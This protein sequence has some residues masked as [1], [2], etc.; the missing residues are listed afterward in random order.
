M[1]FMSAPPLDVVD[2]EFDHIFVAD[3]GHFVRLEL[4]W[5]PLNNIN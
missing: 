1:L 3:S 5:C 4:V 2:G